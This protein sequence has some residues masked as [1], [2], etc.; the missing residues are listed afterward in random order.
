MNVISTKQATG[1]IVEQA[2]FLVNQL[3]KVRGHDKPPFLAGEFAQL[4]NIKR[5]QRTNLGETSAALLKFK[6]G[7]VIKVNE[8]HHPARQNFSIAHEIGHTLFSEL[9]L[10]EYIRSI[11]YRTFNPQAL[12][13]SRSSARERLCDAAATELLMPEA[14]FKKYLTSFG[15]S[16]NSIEPLAHIFRTSIPATAYRIAEV[17]EEPCLVLIWKPWPPNKPNG[18]RYAGSRSTSRPYPVKTFVRRPSS[19]QTAFEGS[20]SVRSSR[21]FIIGNTKQSLPIESKGFGNGDHRYVVS[22]AFLNR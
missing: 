19:L 6:D 11:E 18:L 17:S 15:L 9:K 12:I 13:R 22:L 10:E 7:Y 21:K 2:K 4:R 5:I 16:A 8:K 14:V 3:I 20:S 1:L